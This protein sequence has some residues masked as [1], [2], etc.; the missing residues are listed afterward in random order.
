MQKTYAKIVLSFLTIFISTL[1]FS[2]S[3]VDKKEIVANRIATAINTDGIPNEPEWQKAAIG[4]E[5]IQLEPNPG[6]APNQK[7]EVRVL[8]DDDA[9]YVSAICYDADPENIIRSLSNRDRLDNTDWFGIAVDPYQDGINGYEFIV[10]AAGVQFDARFTNQGEDP[11]WNAVWTSNFQI[12]DQ[13]W[14]VEMRIPYSAI[15]FPNNDQQVWSINFLRYVRSSREKMFWSEIKPDVSGFLN[16]GG[17]VKGIQN[18][19]PPARLFFYPYVSGIVENASDKAA[20]TSDWSYRF[21]GGMDIKYGLNDAFTLDM[22]LIPD[23]SQ[24][25]F[26]NQVLNLSPFEIQFD[27]NRQFFTEG[28]ELFNKGNLFYSRRIGGFPVNYQEEDD[29]GLE[30][31]EEL[32]SNPGETR[33]L[34]ATKISG[35]NKKNTGIGFFNAVVGQTNAIIKNNSNNT[36]RKVETNPLTNYNVLVVDQGLKNNSF[37]SLTNT[38]VLRKGDTYDANVTGTT[39]DLKNKENSYSISGGGAVSQLLYSNQDNDIGFK[40]SL[41][42][43]KISGNFN[44]S[45]G[46]N[47]ESDNYNPNDLGFLFNPNERTL[48]NFS[49]YT[50]Y[51]GFWKFNRMGINMYT[52]Y[53]RLYK[54]NVFSSLSFSP[55]VFFIWN[56]FFANGFEFDYNPM[57]KKDYF[58]PRT[59]DLSAYYKVPANFMAGGWISSDY[60]KTF[61][62]DVRSYYRTFFDSEYHGFDLAIIPR[63]RPNDQMLIIY[64]F[65]QNYR[66]NQEGYADNFFD[67]TAE[68]DQIIYGKRNI[69]TFEN[70]LDFTYIFTNRMGLGMI[71]RHYWSRADYK[72]FHKLNPK[73]G[74]DYSSYSGIDEDGIA[75]NNSNFNAFT[76]DLNFKWQFAP[77]SEL[78]LNWKNSIFTSGNETEIAYGQNFKETWNSPKTNSISLKVLYFIDYLNLKSLFQ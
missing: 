28:T 42:F 60:R 69:T 34:N 30:E 33:L 7:T 11:S 68:E 50:F 29:L 78:N 59:D 56:N 77:G 67:E 22:T 12:T 73:G 58:D 53:S 48:W 8:Y 54:P 45:L 35:R 25:K 75:F 32:I 14:T 63:V 21:A 13:G 70:A 24:V 26:D 4:T 10:S 44:S 31:G 6:T 27:E 20:N 49:S 17:L 18:I 71:A 19:E 52:E 5:F 38:N 15:R 51:D 37:I 74:L 9:I 2:Q 55:S 62:I 46:Y 36:E 39:F 47:V 72:S 3:N 43:N 76:I 16:Q 66:W 41:Q 1:L 65:N 61:A 64:S 40:Y 57:G 23:F